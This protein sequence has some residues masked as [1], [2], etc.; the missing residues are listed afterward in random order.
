MPL[1]L[2]AHL[3]FLSK[4]LEK[5]VAAQ[6][7]EHLQR[8]SLLE[9]FQSCFRTANSTET[10]LLR[11]TNDLL[12]STDS[13]S[14]SLLIVLDL[15]VAFDTV[16]HH[17]LLICLHTNIGLRHTTLDWLISYLSNT[18]QYVSLGS[19]RSQTAPVTHTPLLFII[20]MLPLG[21][22]ISRHGSS[23]HCYADDTL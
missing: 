9:I 13:G 23:F 12:I 19:A 17:I 14:P 11:V 1:Q 22:V 7:Q 8:H 15:S 6:L 20:Y 2:P 5:A 3:P 16:D 4:V 10:A 21:R 18:T